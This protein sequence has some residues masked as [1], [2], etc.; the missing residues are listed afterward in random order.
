MT[1]RLKWK[2]WLFVIAGVSATSICFGT[3]KAKPLYDSSSFQDVAVPEHWFVGNAISPNRW[4]LIHASPTEADDPNGPSFGS[5]VEPEV[6]DPRT[7]ALV[8]KLRSG[9]IH[10]HDRIDPKLA[11]VQSIESINENCWKLELEA[12]TPDLRELQIWCEQRG[13][14]VAWI[15][16]GSHAVPEATRNEIIQILNEQLVGTSQ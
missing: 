1:G 8:K 6:E 5:V 9:E 2:V 16:G 11:P 10:S 14:A 7:E 15:E 4:I 3:S 12:K 13:H